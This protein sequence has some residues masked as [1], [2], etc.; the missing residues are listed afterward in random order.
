MLYAK[1]Q[2]LK[3][4]ANDAAE[5]SHIAWLVGWHQKDCSLIS[6]Y[7]SLLYLVAVVYSHLWS[8]GI[9]DEEE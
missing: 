1:A 9:I 5:R 2:G 8:G 3:I 6:T 7:F 4:I